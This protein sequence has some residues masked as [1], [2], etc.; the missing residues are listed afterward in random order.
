M[1]GLTSTTPE[2]H[3]DVPHTSAFNATHKHQRSTPQVKSSLCCGSTSY[4]ILR[5]IALQGCN[6]KVL[7]IY[8]WAARLCDLDAHN[9]RLSCVATPPGATNQQ[10]QDPEC[11]RKQCHESRCARSTCPRPHRLTWPTMIAV[12]LKRDS[13]RWCSTSAKHTPQ[14]HLFT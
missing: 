8:D 7:G 14:Q 4:V 11:S 1:I 10:E 12:L 3:H 5:D 9:R 2:E 6:Q 13:S